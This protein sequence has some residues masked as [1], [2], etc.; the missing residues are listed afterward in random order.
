MITHRRNFILGLAGVAAGC[1]SL[2]KMSPGDTAPVSVDIF[3]DRMREVIDPGARLVERASSFTWSEGPAW[4]PERDRLYFSDVPEN[5][6]WMWSEAKG[7]DLFLSPSGAADVAGFREPGSNGMWFA[8]DGSLLVCNHGRR[9]VE[10]LDI[11]TLR[12]SVVADQFDGKPFNSPNDVVEAT[13]GTIYFTDPPYGLEGMN[14]SPLKVLPFN[15]VYRLRPGGPVELIVDD[16]TFPNGIALSPDETR[17]YISQSDPDR[18]IL[19]QLVL[20]ADGAIASDTVLFDATDH[21]AD[22]SPGLPDGMAVDVRGRIFLTGPGGIFVVAPDGTAMGRIRLDRATANCAFGG[23][24]SR[25][26][27]TSSDTLYELATNT[28][29][30][31]WRG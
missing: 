9:C 22:G 10:K 2:G 27:I 21:A 11:D 17:L 13:D 15:G 25:L 14:E 31:Q 23:D 16:M 7:L 4:D 29:G 20:G 8:R 1:Q 30:I 26:F 12:R 19:R 24:G 6:A 28:L 5:K 18:P 3:D